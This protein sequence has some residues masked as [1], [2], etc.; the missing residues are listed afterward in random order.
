MVAP[1][2]GVWIEIQG[3]LEKDREI[4]VAPFA[5]VWIEICNHKRRRT[6]AHV[7]PFA[8]VWIEILLCTSL[9]IIF[10]SPFAGVWIE[11]PLLKEGCTQR[12]RRTLRGC[13]D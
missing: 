6:A 11:I 12:A 7:A 10:S 13:V 8:G 5:G 4:L 9:F 3:D 2:A 1:F